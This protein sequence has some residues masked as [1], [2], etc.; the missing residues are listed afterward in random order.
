M[1]VSL[2]TPSTTEIHKYEHALGGG[3]C[4][5]FHIGAFNLASL[6]AKIPGKMT[7]SASYGQKREREHLK[8]DNIGMFLDS[9]KVQHHLLGITITSES[10]AYGKV[11]SVTCP[12]GDAS[13]LERPLWD[14]FSFA[15]K[16]KSGLS[17]IGGWKESP[18]HT[19]DEIKAGI[20]EDVAVF[21]GGQ[22]F[23]D[24]GEFLD[25]E[26][27]DPQIKDFFKTIFKVDEFIALKEENKEFKPK[28]PPEQT[29]KSSPEQATTE[30]H[31]N[32]KSPASFNNLYLK[33]KFMQDFGE[34]LSHVD[35]PKGDAVTK[36]AEELKQKVDEFSKQI[37]QEPPS[38]EDIKRFQADFKKLLHSQD[39]IMKEHREILKPIVANIL[40]SLLTLG[41]GLLAISIKAGV[42][43]VRAYQDDR[44]IAASDILFF[45]QTKREQA[46]D[47]IEKDIESSETYKGLDKNK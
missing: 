23:I 30:S 11:L 31:E 29:T 34:T 16:P 9:F 38:P 7:V 27:K 46:I 2:F 43:A 32:L 39:N 8:A 22:I 5:Y 35:K 28:A 21:S 4:H 6:L 14:V 20:R 18:G 15:V 44:K 13:N 33:I 24:L 10:G 47:T 37:S 40:F 41:I 1:Q 17:D 26:V 12:E 45:A 19:E 36:L 3:K 42:G 25:K